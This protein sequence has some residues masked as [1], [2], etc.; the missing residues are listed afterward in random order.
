[1]KYLISLLVFVSLNASAKSMLDLHF[2]N[3]CWVGPLNGTSVEECWGTS[4]GNLMLGTSKTLE[5][6]Q[7]QGFEFLS[8]KQVNQEIIY[9]P[10]FNGIELKSFKVVSLRGGEVILSNPE[11]DYPKEIRYTLKNRSLEVS[12]TGLAPNGEVQSV[13]YKMVRKLK[14]D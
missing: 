7:V 4:S 13:T 8:F 6:G 9:T 3:G 12:L 10:Y 11:N 2:L 5:R 14:R 1:M